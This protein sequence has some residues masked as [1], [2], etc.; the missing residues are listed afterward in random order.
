[1]YP[2]GGPPWLILADMQTI[3]LFRYAQLARDRTRRDRVYRRLMEV[4]RS[5]T[6]TT[7][8]WGSRIKCPLNLKINW[9]DWCQFPPPP[10]FRRFRESS[11]RRK[12]AVVLSDDTWEPS[13]DTQMLAT[14]P[15]LSSKLPYRCN[16]QC[17][18]KLDYIFFSS[19]DCSS[20][21]HKNLHMRLFYSQFHFLIFA[22]G[23]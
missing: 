2:R 19:R 6:N 9:N 20:S 4:T 5:L 13:R 1:M 12:H 10:S 8:V 18:E 14:H 3:R 17:L 7:L 22:W 21:L 23:E 15:P 16:L 11:P